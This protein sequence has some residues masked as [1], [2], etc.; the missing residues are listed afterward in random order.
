M[1][2][3]WSMSLHKWDV[4][5]VDF[6]FGKEGKGYL[7]KRRTDREVVRRKRGR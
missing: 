4:G 3:T 2:T 1:I 5:Y 6:L 7:V